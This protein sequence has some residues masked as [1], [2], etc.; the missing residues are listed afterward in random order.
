MSEGIAPV[1]PQSVAAS[2]VSRLLKIPAEPH[3]PAGDP[4]SVRVFRAARGYY[5]YL[6]ALWGMKQGLALAGVL[7]AF[8]MLD[9]VPD[10]PGR[11]LLDIAEWLGLLF[12]LSTIPL[13]YLMVHLDYQM[14]WYIITDRSLRIREGL[15]E[16][17][18]Q[19]MSFANI[20]NMS[21]QQGPI[22]RLFGIADLKVQTAGG[23]SAATPGEAHAGSNMH[24]AYFR[25]VDNAEQI[26][27]AVLARVR[28][29]RDSGLG[30]PDHEHDQPHVD[31]ATTSLE[32]I[33]AARELLAEARALRK[34]AEPRL[35]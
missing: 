6:L 20:Q 25:G 17:R 11:F 8:F 1:Q 2:F 13:S 21:I 27:D 3:L 4:E 9:M 14:R 31:H 16:I 12:F 5:T 10:F 33:E 30:D 28:Q 26:R 32:A 15:L 29:L 7:F 34:A 19:T 18:E 35:A 24:Q 22:Q 23:G